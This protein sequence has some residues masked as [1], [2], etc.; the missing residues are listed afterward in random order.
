M[1]DAMAGTTGCNTDGIEQAT[2][3]TDG[4]APRAACMKA[5]QKL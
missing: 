3:G 4:K 1:A 2:R 5:G